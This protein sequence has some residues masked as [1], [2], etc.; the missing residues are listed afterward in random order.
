[1][2]ALF[3]KHTLAS[4]APAVSTI[5]ATVH[6]PTNTLKMMSVSSFHFWG[7]VKILIE[8]YVLGGKLMSMDR[9]K[10]FLTTVGYSSS[11]FT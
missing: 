1:M 10:L 4:H 9:Y 5:T 7:I 3:A 11:F 2:S 8:E 6:I